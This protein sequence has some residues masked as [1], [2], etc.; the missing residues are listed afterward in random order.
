MEHEETMWL[1]LTKTAK[2][3]EYPRGQY[4]PKPL[5]FLSFIQRAVKTQRNKAKGKQEISTTLKGVKN[6]D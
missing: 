1:R 4:Y 5:G 2:E 6:N 3:G